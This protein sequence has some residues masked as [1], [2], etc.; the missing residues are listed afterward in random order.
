MR[1]IIVSLDALASKPLRDHLDAMN[2]TERK[3]L[4]WLQ[5]ASLL[6]AF[7]LLAGC[8]APTRYFRAQVVD[9]ATGRGIPLVELVT[10]D[11]VLYVTDSAGVAAI[12]Y[13]E[14]TGQFVYFQP[15]SHGYEPEKDNLGFEGFLAKIEP[16]GTTTVGMRRINV[17]ERLYRVTGEGIYHDSVL[18]GDAV[19]LRKPWLNGGVMGQDSVNA[20]LYHGKLYWFWGDTKRASSPLGNF[21]VSGAISDLPGYGGLDPAQGVDLTYFVDAQGFSRSMCPLDGP[22]AVWIDGLM[23]L[24]SDGGE[25]LLCHY[26][27]MKGLGN[28]LEQGIAIWNDDTATFE[29]FKVFPLDAPLYP[30]GNP[31]RVEQDG[32]TWLYFANPFP[33]TRVRARVDDIVDPTRY[34]AYTCLRP[35]TRWDAE[36]PPL[37]RSP[38]GELV[39]G[40]KADTAAV[41]NMQWQQLVEEG[42]VADDEGWMNLT[43]VETGNRIVAHSGS[44]TWNSYLR[45]WV[46]LALQFGGQSSLLGEVWYAEAETLMGPWQRTRRVVTHDHYSFYNVVQHPYFAQ[47]GGRLIYFEGTYSDMFSGNPRRTPRYNYN[48]IMYR[49]DLDDPRLRSAQ[50]R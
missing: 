38:S 22:G 28:R 49:L 4:Q 13:P 20:A 40:W 10:V 14:L 5:I 3:S 48:Q 27:R 31:I 25:Q 45:K 11:D 8:A 36:K 34:E 39:W 35:G 21:S 46:M 2:F 6:C 9:E 32:Q 24:Q 7:T 1:Q 18:L 29:K 42:L 41:S 16:G 30:Q 44:V 50:S 47:E 19:P 15:F 26:S 12:E 37:D 17:A 23:S 33:A 43:D